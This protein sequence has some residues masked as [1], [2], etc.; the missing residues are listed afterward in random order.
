MLVPVLCFTCGLPI[1]EVDDLFRGMREALVRAA[2]AGRDTTA[3]QAAVDAG[4]QID[5][6]PLLD[7][8]G[9][10]HDCCRKSIVTAMHF[11]DYY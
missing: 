3:T 7:A 5:C 10:T 11:C 4:L 2:L 9:I 1:G 6:G 8:L